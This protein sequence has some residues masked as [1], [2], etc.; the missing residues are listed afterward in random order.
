MDLKNNDLINNLYPVYLKIFKWFLNIW[1]TYFTFRIAQHIEH[2]LGESAVLTLPTT[3]GPA[4][5]LAQPPA[6]LD[7]WR[8]SCIS[9]TC[10][11]GLSGLPQVTKPRADGSGC[12]LRV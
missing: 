12:R 5:P 6:E 11:A 1:D 2:L 8:R 4:P 7:S 3:P 10:I 9:L